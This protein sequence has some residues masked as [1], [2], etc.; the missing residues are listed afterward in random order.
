MRPLGTGQWSVGQ[1]SP[2]GSDRSMAGKTNECRREKIRL[3]D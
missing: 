2:S 1:L 3:L